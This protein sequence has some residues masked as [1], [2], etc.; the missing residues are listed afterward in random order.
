M[1][2]KKALIALGIA[3][4]LLIGL[5]LA[6]SLR[7]GGVAAGRRIGVVEVRGFLADPQSAVDALRDLRKD[8]GIKAVVVRVES[9]GGL[10][11]PSQ[12]IH[13]E[14]ARTA[15]VKPVVVSM[16]VVAASGGYYLAAPATRIVA[17]PGTATGSIGV[18]LKFDEV[19]GLL[20]KLGV[21]TGVVK[22]GAMKDAGS[23]FRPMSTQEKA[24]FQGLV[25]DIFAQ[26]VD[27]VA[28]GR[29]MDRERVLALADGRVYSGRQAQKLGLVDELGGFWDAVARAQTLAG[30]SGEP[31]LDYRGKKSGGLLRLILGEDSDALAPLHSV[32]AGPLRL[33]VPGW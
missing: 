32:S 14:L 9:P 22:S 26:F 6:L 21:R 8:E 19:H 27:A 2:R 31:E 15:A 25:D 23:P 12:E 30:L 33:E 17:D 29:K 13:D 10:V 16:G 20:D 28:R 1:T 24:V 5:C 3:A 7:P 11:A 4:A 18:I